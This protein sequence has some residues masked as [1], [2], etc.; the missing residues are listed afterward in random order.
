MVEYAIS[1]LMD[2]ILDDYVSHKFQLCT[3][4]NMITFQKSRDSRL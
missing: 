1:A 2:N 4:P 3:R